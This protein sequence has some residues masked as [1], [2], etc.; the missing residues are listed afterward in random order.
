VVAGHEVDLRQRDDRA[1]DPEEVEDVDV[2]AGLEHRPVV[3]RDDEERQVHRRRARDHRAD[4]PLVAGDVD[5]PHL[6]VVGEPEL[7]VSDV[8]RHPALLLLGETVRADA[9]QALDQ[10]R[11]AV[12]DVP[13]GPH[14]D[15][16]DGGGGCHAASLPA[17]SSPPPVASEA[18]S[19]ALV[20]SKRSR[21]PRVKG[22][23][24]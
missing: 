13:G 20:G 3:G 5:Q 11:L 21:N 19:R 6:G 24:W 1:A 2:L 23:D 22:V 12:V 18:R 7:G 8:D 16:A 9:R 4:E 14:D 10:R 17:D 15:A